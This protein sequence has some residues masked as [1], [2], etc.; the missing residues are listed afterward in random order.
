MAALARRI[1]TLFGS[2]QDV[3]WTVVDRDITVLQAR[4][5]TTTAASSITSP[6]SSRKR[7][8]RAWRGS[9][10]LPSSCSLICGTVGPDI[11]TMPT[12]PRPGGVATAAMVSV[13]VVVT[14]TP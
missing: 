10:N 11:R 6:S 14:A 12:P 8:K 2:P 9:G 7:A 13:T 3:E 1:E 5:V 4:P